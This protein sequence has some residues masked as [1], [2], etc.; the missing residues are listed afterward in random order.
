MDRPEVGV[1]VGRLIATAGLAASLAV[2]A[3]L[4]APG[5]GAAPPDA[6]VRMTNQLAFQAGEVRIPVGGVVEWHND[7]VLVHTVTADP[8]EAA[9]PEKSVALPEGAQ[10]F[11]SGLLDPGERWRHRFEEP[12]R[13]RYF[14]IPHEAAG[15]LG[16]VVVGDAELESAEDP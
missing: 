5:D 7:S 6:T 3:P 16:T 15:M 14:C 13:Y 1:G 11:D 4:T 2:L 8:A 12:G 9:Q 10:P